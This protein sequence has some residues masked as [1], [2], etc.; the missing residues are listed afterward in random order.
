ITLGWDLRT[1][2]AALQSP[3][4][5]PTAAVGNASRNTRILAMDAYSEELKAE[6]VYRFDVASTFGGPPPPAPAPVP[7]DMKI[8]A[9]VAPLCSWRVFVPGG[10]YCIAK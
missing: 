10:A 6:Y 1:L 5:N 3:L 2:Y 8:S 9:D 7:A 4:V